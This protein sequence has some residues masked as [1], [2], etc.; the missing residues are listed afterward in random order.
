MAESLGAEPAV[1]GIRVDYVVGGSP[2]LAPQ[3][4]SVGPTDWSSDRLEEQ[5]LALIEAQLTDDVL[6]D[7]EL[8]TALPV[9]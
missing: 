5:R 8:A 9:R 7:D 6:A 3:F 2:S 1:T 4:A